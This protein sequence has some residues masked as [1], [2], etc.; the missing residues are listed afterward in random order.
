M[1]RLPASA[2]WQ[3]IKQ[4]MALFRKQPFEMSALF[5]SYVFLMFAFGIIPLIGQ[6]LPMVLVPVFTMAF[7]QACVSIERGT[8]VY[9]TMLLYGFRSPAFRRLL[10]LGS[11]YIVA[12]LLAI[13]AS[14]LVDGG[15]FWKITT[16]QAAVDPE[17]V[18]GSNITMA[19][20]FAALVYTPAA[21]GFWYAAPLIAW[22]DMGV[23]KAIFY[24]FFSVKRNGRAFL[25]YALSWAG[26][27]ILLPAIAGSVL[28]L[29]FGRSTVMM[30]FLLPL[31]LVMTVIMY[32]SFYP[33]FTDVFGP[34]AKA[35]SDDRP[36]DRPSP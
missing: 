4:G 30:L 31:S 19:M 22:H 33:N 7:M 13:G 8:K 18:R 29:L 6:I 5:L 21:M 26:V 1:D 35:L 24:S 36:S 15:V 9:P 20:L 3:W 16:G 11:L 23:G 12:A 2:G 14:T 32:C 34:P 28:G 17:T 27:G 10:L 25:T